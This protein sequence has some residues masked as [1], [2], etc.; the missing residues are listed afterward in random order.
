MSI[1]TVLPYGASWP[2][3]DW[4]IRGCICSAM[5]S[6]PLH[7]RQSR[8]T[9]GE[10]GSPGTLT[11]FWG[12]GCIENGV[13]N[14]S[15][16]FRGS[17]IFRDRKTLSGEREEKGKGFAS[18]GRRPEVAAEAASG[19]EISRP[20]YYSEEGKELNLG[21]RKRMGGESGQKREYPIPG[22]RVKKVTSAQGLSCGSRTG[23][24]KKK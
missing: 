13:T 12:S 8:Y 10:E 1:G 20:T 7:Q 9:S 11:N 4:T 15:E 2:G 17:A 21:R 3:D 6:M 16:S 14:A 24:R 23:G 18:P 19:C 5:Y 22:P